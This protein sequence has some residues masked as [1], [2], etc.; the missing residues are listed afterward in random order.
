MKAGIVA[1]IGR[2]NV[3][4]STLLN[5]VIGQ[6]VSIVSDVPQTTRN[7]IKGVYSGEQGQIVFLDTPG[8]NLLRGLLSRQFSSA[9]V[10]SLNDADVVLYV[11]DLQDKIGKEERFI[12]DTLSQ[13]SVPIVVAMNKKDLGKGY[14]DSYV[15]ELS[16]IAKF[17]VPVSAIRNEG[18]DEL[19]SSLFELLPE[20]ER[21]LVPQ[22]MKSDLPLE[23]FVA[24]V[25]R[26]KFLWH[27][28]D[29]IPHGLAVVVEQME[30]REGLLYIKALILVAKETHKQVVI[31]KQ[32][33][34]IKEAGK[35]ARK[36]LKSFLG[37]KIFLDLWVSVK[38]WAKEPSIMERLGYA[39]T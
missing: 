17:F 19:L 25:I 6:K 20:V 31:G 9:A 1:I 35:L 3:G 27:L 23:L 14:V 38:N 5:A 33:R 39:G 8:I 2:C 11:V 22:N 13:V 37:K 36:E 4:K 29:E 24:E 28:K 32:G 34:L 30:E 12:I 7:R 15:R 18:V 21:P 16:A 26:E 10:A